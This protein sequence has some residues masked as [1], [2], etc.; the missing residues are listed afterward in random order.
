MMMV[1]AERYF[2]LQLFWTKGFGQKQNCDFYKF[3]PN[4]RHFCS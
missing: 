4:I 2:M 1:H 3:E